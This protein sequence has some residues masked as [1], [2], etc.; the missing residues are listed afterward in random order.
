MDRCA[1]VKRLLLLALV[2]LGALVS[3]SSACTSVLGIPGECRVE[4]HRVRLDS[5]GAVV[6]TKTL[7]EVR[8]PG[9]WTTRACLTSWDGR[10]TVAY[11]GAT[12]SREGIVFASYADIGAR[13]KLRGGTSR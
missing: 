2:L 11:R 8:V 13:K 12:W 3:A 7:S 1:D 10:A 9:I 6:E 5:S 4:V